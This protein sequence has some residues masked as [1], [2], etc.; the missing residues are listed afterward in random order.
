[1]MDTREVSGRS[2]SI[3]AARGMTGEKI[4]NVVPI[5]ADG[6]PRM[7]PLAANFEIAVREED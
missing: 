5:R 2:S 6:H 3:F 7:P 4:G 1:M